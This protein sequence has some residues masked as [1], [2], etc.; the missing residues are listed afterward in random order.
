MKKYLHFG[1]IVICALIIVSNIFLFLHSKKGGGILFELISDITPGAIAMTE[2]STY[3]SEIGQ[4][5]IQAALSKGH[6]TDALQNLKKAVELLRKHGKIHL[7]HEQHIGVEESKSAEL[8]IEK[9]NVLAESVIVFYQLDSDCDLEKLQTNELKVVHEATSNLQ[10]ILLSHKD[11]HLEE[12]SVAHTLIKSK[13]KTLNTVIISSS[14]ILLIIFISIWWMT[15]IVYNRFTEEQNS[16]QKQIK[17][18]FIKREEIEEKL[19]QA[20]KMESIGL[21]AGGVAHDLN[22]I[23]S[24]VTGYSELILYD[25]PGDNKLRKPLEA[26]HDS[27]LRAAVIVADLLTVARSAAS[28]RKLQN[29]NSLAEE[30]LDSP[31]YMALKGLYQQV[32]CQRQ[33][34]AADASILC[35]SVHVKKCLMNLVTNAVEAVAEDGEI[36]ISTENKTITEEDTAQYHTEKGEYVV[37]SV[38]DNGSGIDDVDLERIFEPFYT[39][40]IMGRSGTGL[41]LAVVWNTMKDHDGVVLVNSNNRGTCFQLFFPVTQEK[42]VVLKKESGKEALTGNGERILLVDDERSLREVGYQMLKI[43]G[44]DV[45][46]LSSGEQAVEFVKENRVDLVVLD[47]LMDPGMNGCRTYEKILEISPDQKAVIASGFSES[48]D[49]K[50]ALK[51]G[52]SEFISKPYSREQLGRAVKKALCTP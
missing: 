47:M 27:G 38:Q 14:I 13:K 51:L 33:L 17:E 31:E 11:I 24:G 39:K 5:S 45:V 25:L 18:D 40:K 19:S 35:S 29:L 22:N 43:L 30:Y 21:M 42:K 36:I 1:F 16:Q 10:T 7:E 34:T 28:T 49:V 4:Y 41:G 6:D 48:G 8:L 9:I 52:A 32:S 37:L 12:L 2:M 44:Y 23:L 46:S 3:T 20:K 50:K 26:I 15:I